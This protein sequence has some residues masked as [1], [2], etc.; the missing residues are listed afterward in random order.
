MIKIQES[1]P[2]IYYD[3]SRDFQLIGHLFDLVLNSTKT[4]AD[5]L[6][7][8][9]LSTNSDDQLLELL[10]FTLGLRLS[11]DKYTTRQLRAVCE[12]APKIMRNKGSKQAIELLCKAL[13]RADSI[14]GSSY[15]TLLDNKLTVY[16]TNV[17]TC[18]DIL[19]EL[20]PY[21]VPAGI[22]FNIKEMTWQQAPTQ[23]QLELSDQVVISQASLHNK[24]N[25]YYYDHEQDPQLTDIQATPLD[26]SITGETLINGLPESATTNGSLWAGLTFTEEITE[27]ENPN[28]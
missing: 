20:L 4:E 11:K 7:N 8:L 23:T 5:L 9:P 15:I 28:V 10:A 18:H 1:V 6:F 17:A 24:L 3:S 21:I 12:V 25:Y 22:V 13:L 14:E 2:N 26:F 19:I 16:I 27:G